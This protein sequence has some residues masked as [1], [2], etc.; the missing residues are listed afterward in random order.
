M[1]LPPTHRVQARTNTLSMQQS[2]QGLLAVLAAVLI[3]GCSE[4]AFTPSSGPAPSYYQPTSPPAPFVNAGA[5]Q[6]TSAGKTYTLYSGMSSPAAFIPKN[7]ANAEVACRNQVGGHLASFSTDEQWSV[8]SALA[9]AAYASTGTGR[10]LLLWTGLNNLRTAANAFSDGSSTAYVANNLTLATP[11]RSRSA[12][13][14]PA[15][16]SWSAPPA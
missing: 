5:T 12:R 7:W 2:I 15:S 13:P 16:R 3:A 4:A 14:R 6:Q 8:V 10:P 11:R 9:T 1:C